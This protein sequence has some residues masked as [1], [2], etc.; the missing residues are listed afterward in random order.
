[1]A[2]FVCKT[3]FLPT[4][5][6]GMEIFM[7]ILSKYLSKTKYESYEDFCNNFE[8]KVPVDFDFARD[9][10]DKWAMIEPTKK[11]LVYCDDENR[12]RV[13]TF[14]DISEQSKKAATYFKS[15]GIKRG[16]GCLRFC[17]DD[18]NTGFV[19]LRFTDWEQP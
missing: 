17:E 16:T 19:P 11:A 6:G 12:E 9:V 2:F 14:T 5:G 13:F 10:V 3:L 15:L 7:E 18:M 8:I 1:M 4:R